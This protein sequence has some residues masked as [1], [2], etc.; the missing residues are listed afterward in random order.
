MVLG[1]PGPQRVVQLPDISWDQYTSGLGDFER[2]FCDRKRNTRR[3][4]LIFDKGESAV[5]APECETLLSPYPLRKD[6][7]TSAPTRCSRLCLHIR[8]VLFQPLICPLLSVVVCIFTL[9]AICYRPLRSHVAFFR[10]GVA[11]S[12]KKPSG[13]QKGRR[14]FSTV[15]RAAL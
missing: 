3:T 8:P 9:A 15:L 10:S 12:T 6:V 5:L 13:F 7:S 1:L 11:S 14:V 4:K 2:E